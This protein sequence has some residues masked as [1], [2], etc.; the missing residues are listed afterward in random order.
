[1]NAPARILEQ[2]YR[3]YDGPRLGRGH[4]IRSLIAHTLRRILG[5]RRPARYK[6]LPVLS[7]V[8]AYVPAIVFVGVV[9]LLGGFQNGGDPGRGPGGGGDG[10]PG[11]GGGVGGPGADAIVPPYSGYYGF[12]LSAIILFV[13][14]VAPEALCPDRRSKVLSLYLSAPLTRLRYLVAKAGA[15]AIVLSSVT[16]GPPLLLLLGR[17]LQSQGPDGVGG[18][19]ATFARIL[20]SGLMLTG[21]FTAVSLGV[22]S[23][24]DR[25][26]VAAAATLLLVIGSNAIAG[27]LVFTGAT[28]GILALSLTQAP[29]RLVSFIFG[30]TQFVFPISLGPLVAG[31]GGWTLVGAAVAVTRLQRLQVTR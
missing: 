3:R 18:F 27:A 15:V 16:I 20:A 25:R 13:T 6:I 28:R 30:E 14:F 29:F 22:A 24:T 1:M 7:I 2:G 23:L 9:A 11:G 31:V 19:F 26:A 12:I 5:L 21:I 4:A 8:L 10:G 17:T